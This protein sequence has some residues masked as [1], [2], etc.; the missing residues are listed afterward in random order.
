[1]RRI[2]NHILPVLVVLGV[3]A[4]QAA[5]E[6]RLIRVGGNVQQTKRISA[7][8][9]AYPAEAKRDRVQGNVQLQVIIDK[10][11]HVAEVSVLQGPDVLVQAAVEA[12]RQWVYEPTLLNGERVR[13]ATTIDVNFTL[14]Q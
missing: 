4:S 3:M 7:V 11:G 13:V 1:V 8:M 12:V 5:A 10:E 14:A 9:P 2:L 6:D